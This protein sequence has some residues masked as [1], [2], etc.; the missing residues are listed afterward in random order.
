[1]QLGDEVLADGAADVSSE[2][3]Q[4]L[5]LGYE[6]FVRTVVLP[7]GDFARF[8]TANKAERQTLLRSLLGLDVYTTVRNLARTRGA[9]A[10]ERVDAAVRFLDG[11]AIPEDAEITFA[12]RCYDVLVD[13]S[14][15]IVDSEGRLSALVE[16]ANLA[17]GEVSKLDGRVARLTSVKAPRRFTELEALATEARASLGAAEESIAKSSERI[18]TLNGRLNKLPTVETIKTHRADHELASDLDSRL[19]NQ[20]LEKLVTEERAA[21]ANHGKVV[22]EL[23][24]VRKSL[25]TTRLAHSAH[26]LSATLGSWGQ[27]P[28][29]R[30]SCRGTPGSGES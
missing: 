21:Q 17:D 15:H 16:A 14:D 3:G 24:L 2:V 23:V 8:L 20:D 6:E 28:C 12:A 27:V 11:L 29:L 1:M 10:T 22:D 25:T 30:H 19:E 18:D 26:A 13:L 9:V 4:L 5:K 7:Q